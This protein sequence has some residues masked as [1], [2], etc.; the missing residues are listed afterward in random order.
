VKLRRVK[1]GRDCDVL[2]GRVVDPARLLY[3]PIGVDPNNSADWPEVVLLLGIN[4][5][6]LPRRKPLI[7]F[8]V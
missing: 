1:I 5:M 6:I 4:N 3:P 2:A 7:P 8:V